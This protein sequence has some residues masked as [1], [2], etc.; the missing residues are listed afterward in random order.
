MNRISPLATLLIT[1]PLLATA[2]P[3]AADTG[4][5]LHDAGCKS[6]HDSSVY[7]REDRR[8]KDLGQLHEQVRRCQ[9]ANDLAWSDKDIDA[10]ATFLNAS[11]Y[12]F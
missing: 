3:A 1:L 6:C 7:T 11:Y 5:E 4:P 9:K 2:M 12:K 8:V 10:V